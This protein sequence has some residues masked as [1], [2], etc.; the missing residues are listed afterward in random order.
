VKESRRWRW[1]AIPIY[2]HLLSL[3]AP[4]VAVLWAWSLARTAQVHPHPSALAVLAIGAWLIYIA[5]RL[6]DGLPGADPGNLRERHHFHSR[7]RREL[8]IAGVAASALLLGFIVRMPA[9]ARQEDASLFAVAMLYFAAVHLPA[10]RI[11][12]PRELAVGILFACA[13][14][15]PAWSRSIPAHPQ[16]AGLTT[17]FAALCWLNCR[18][19]H[20][21]EQAPAGTRTWQISVFALGLAAAAATSM[22]FLSPPEL[23]LASAILAAALLLF[24]LDRDRRRSLQRRIPGE[25]LSPLAL[26]ILADAALLTPLLLLIPWHR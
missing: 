13:C 18:A 25:A 19:I 12:F 15:V 7:H 1:A 4:T 21:W 9:A 26:R 11:R 5:D 10:L 20:V 24:A 3:D 16:L 2:W 8:L 23:R 22:F 14:A 17:L 6:L